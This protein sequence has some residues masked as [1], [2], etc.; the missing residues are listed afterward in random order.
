[1]SN[2]IFELSI[3]FPRRHPGQLEIV[4]SLLS[5]L[6]VPKAN[7]IESAVKENILV[8]AYFNSSRALES[9][10]RVLKTFRLQ[11]LKIQSKILKNKD[12]LERWKDDWHIFALTKTIDVVPTWRRQGYIPGERK[13]ILLDTVSSFGTGLHETTQF[14]AELIETKQGDFESFFD[15]GT[16]TGILS[17]VAFCCGAQVVHAVDL[18]P[19][20]IR[21]AKENMK[22][23]DLGFDKI[24]TADAG[25]M[26]RDLRFDFVAANL[27]THDLIL[28]RRKIV[29][30][31]KPGKWLAVSG[32]SLN[33]LVKLKQAFKELPLRCVK[34][35]KGK[36]WAAVLY[37][38]KGKGRG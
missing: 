31:V 24:Q 26:R 30:F 9:I 3:Q 17:L 22:A 15:I 7:I 32:I 27:I 36:Q 21:T 29:S 14:V 8:S 23:N 34:V 4:G 20:S 16:G 19:Q 33:N 13:Y 25:A 6:G 18:S 12:W 1:M 28:M 5:N 10:H 35:K 38:K 11:N 2:K 37:Q